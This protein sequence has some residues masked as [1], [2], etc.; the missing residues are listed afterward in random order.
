MRA[1]PGRLGAKM[2]AQGRAAPFDR[3]QGVSARI[4]AAAQSAPEAA[5]RPGAAAN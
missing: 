2:L 4:S 5:R 3:D 1:A